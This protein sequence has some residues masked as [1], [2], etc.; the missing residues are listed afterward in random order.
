M[1]NK[2]AFRR[3]DKREIE[4]AHARGKREI[5]KF[6]K[7]DMNVHLINGKWCIKSFI[8][9]THPMIVSPR[10]KVYLHSH[11]KLCNEE[12]TKVIMDEY[13]TCEIK[14]TKLSCLLM[15]LVRV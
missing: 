9:H 12:Q 4:R 11:D 13:H 7:T 14:P 6:Y 5:R 10:K 8:T 15:K 1:C 3:T 2:E